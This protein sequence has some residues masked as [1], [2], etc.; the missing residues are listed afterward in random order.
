MKKILALMLAAVFAL[1]LVACGSKAPAAQETQAVA[2]AAPPAAT[3][4]PAAPAPAPV[5]EPEDTETVIEYDLDVLYNN[6]EEAY[7]GG[8]EDGAVVGFG[9]S[10]DG[11][12]AIF[13]VWEG[14]E[15]VT[16]VGPTTVVG[17]NVS[18]EDDVNGLTISFDV[19]AV[20]GDDTG[21]MMMLDLGDAGIAYLELTTV[22]ELLDVLEQ[23]VT[24]SYA[25]G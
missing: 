21:T 10:E 24:N 23:V 4:A 20:P 16:F 17:N 5:A 1:T 3:Q 13:L 11:S 7:F 2:T 12:F 18:I 22:E 19:Q 14:D 6:L 15:H 25:V 9:S 8:T